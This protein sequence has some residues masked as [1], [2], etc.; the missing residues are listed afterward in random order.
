M[1]IHDRAE[2]GLGFATV[3]APMGAR[4]GSGS[5]PGGGAATS[6]SSMRQGFIPTAGDAGR[7]TVNLVACFEI[8]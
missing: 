1:Y 5:G 2:T 8:F 7:T 6:S 3:C 4:L